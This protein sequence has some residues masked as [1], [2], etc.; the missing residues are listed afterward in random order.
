ML[1]AA[2]PVEADGTIS[3]AGRIEHTT[4]KWA[5]SASLVAP[6]IIVTAA[7]CADEPADPL[8]VFRPGDGEEG[9]TY[10]LVSVARHPLY[11]PEMKREDWRLRFDV[12]VARLAHPVPDRRA[13]PFSSGDEARPGET[14]YIVSWRLDGSDRP[15]QRACMVL[16]GKKGLVTLGCPVQGGESGAPVLRKTAEGL[17]LVAV[18]SSRARI[19]DQPVAQASDVALRLPPLLDLIKIK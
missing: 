4:K 1:T 15:R 14:L 5:C 10:P 6:D 16:E 11:D 8:V 7:H 2:D 3:A 9:E 18:I 17:E 13:Q 12:A 19:A